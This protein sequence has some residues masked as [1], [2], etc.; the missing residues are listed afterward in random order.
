[1]QMRVPS[2]IPYLPANIKAIAVPNIM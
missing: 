1:M 2:D